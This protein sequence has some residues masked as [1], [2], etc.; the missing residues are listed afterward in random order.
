MTVKW[1]EIEEVNIFAT[2]IES[3]KDEMHGCRIR[4]VS[5]IEYYVPSVSRKEMTLR[6]AEILLDTEDAPK[7]ATVKPATG[8]TT[9]M[10]QATVAKQRKP[11]FKATT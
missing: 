9:E 10:P 11:T 8:F 4:T 1:I 7:N 2:G 5:G 6:I 3:I